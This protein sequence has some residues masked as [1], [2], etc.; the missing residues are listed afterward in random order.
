M[1]YPSSLKREMIFGLLSISITQN[2]IHKSTAGRRNFKGASASAAFARAM[3]EDLISYRAIEKLDA[4]SLDPDRLDCDED[5][6]EDDVVLTPKGHAYL[7]GLA[8]MAF[9][10]EQ[11][12]WVIRDP[13]NNK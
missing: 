7:E 2:M 5:G 11:L 3:Y 8:E 6:D 4:D 13:R 9:P 12:V 10:V 1:N